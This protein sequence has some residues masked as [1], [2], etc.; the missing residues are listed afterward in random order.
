MDANSLRRVIIRLATTM[1]MTIVGPSAAFLHGG[2]HGLIFY[3]VIIVLSTSIVAELSAISS[4]RKLLYKASPLFLLMPIL[5]NVYTNNTLLFT[6]VNP[7]M[8]GA[9]QG[10][11]WCYFHDIR[12]QLRMQS[13]V[14]EVTSTDRW[15]KLEISTTLV[16][17]FLSTSL[18]YIGHISIA[19]ALGGVFAL[20]AFL[21]PLDSSISW[22]KIGISTHRLD[23][24]DAKRGALMSGSYAIMLWSV[25]TT[26]RLFVFTSNESFS[27]GVFGL[28]AAVAVSSIIGYVIK[29]KSASKT[30]NISCSQSHAKKIWSV[31]HYIAFAFLLGM[32]A[33]I[34]LHGTLFFI[35]YFLF[36]GTTTGV[37]RPLEVHLAGQ[38]LEGESGIGVRERMKFRAK[39]VAIPILTVPQ[40]I[41]PIAIICS[42]LNCRICGDSAEE[43]NK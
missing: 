43:H 25:N 41:I 14:D 35:A 20:V 40:L 32:W 18:S 4:R 34:L 7:L 37:L 8:F 30:C 12:K 29:R 28:G 39:C 36:K 11:F 13:N 2:K 17:V 42:I 38:Y 21:I 24:V 22:N 3:I 19:G 1:L 15:Q 27:I 23:G 5:F 9:Y 10:C 16:G 6:M 31:G 26:M 33:G